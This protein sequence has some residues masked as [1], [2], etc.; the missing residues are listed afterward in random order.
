[1]RTP[2]HTHTKHTHTHI[3]VKGAYE[4]QTYCFG[5]QS[6]VTTSAYVLKGS[7]SQEGAL[8]ATGEAEM[9]LHARK[10]QE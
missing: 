2:T 3:H 5:H 8:L 1:V 4:I 6:F 7:S 9:C 10:Q